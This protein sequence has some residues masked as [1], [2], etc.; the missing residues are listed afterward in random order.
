MDRSKN[1]YIERTLTGPTFSIVGVH[2]F[3]PWEVVARKTRGGL[4]KSKRKTEVIF[5]PVH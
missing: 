2:T 4:A 5:S 3:G 1:L